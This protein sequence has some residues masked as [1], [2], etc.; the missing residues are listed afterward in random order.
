MI[1]LLIRI[2]SFTALSLI[3]LLS[4]CQDRSTHPGG[5]DPLTQW[6]SLNLHDYL[7]IQRRD[8]F[9]VFG[10]QEVQLIVR[11][12]TIVSI[13]LLGYTSE[14][15]LQ[16]KDQYRTVD[17]LFSFIEW[18]SSF[19]SGRLTVTYNAAF[20][21]PERIDFDPYPGFVDDEISYITVGF[22]TIR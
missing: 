6:K 9:C 21:Y 20:G 2:V 22:T 18:A 1:P 11:A 8:C 17:S 13:T 14:V 15:S 3:L 12:D 16:Y 19:P 10:G 5:P 4:S 7:L